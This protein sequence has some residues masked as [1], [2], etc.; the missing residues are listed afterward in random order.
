MTR[1]PLF[2]EP[3]GSV[4]VV[5]R[6]GPAGVHATDLR[7][8]A[9]GGAAQAA[10]LRIVRAAY[11]PPDDAARTRDVTEQLS[12]HV[13]DGRLRLRAF[14]V[15]AGDPAPGVRKELRV[16]YEIGGD[17][18]TGRPERRRIAAPAGTHGNA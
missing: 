4:F 5:F 12:K 16:E 15:L 7:F 11:G 6:P 9:T 13:K 3:A 17:R 2:F 14:T 10:P 8:S 1:I 18:R